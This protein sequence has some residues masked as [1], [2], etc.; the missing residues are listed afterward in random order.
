MIEKQ[1]REQI[2]KETD[3]LLQGGQHTFSFDSRDRLKN[4]CEL[5][6]SNRSR[7]YIQLSSDDDPDLEEDDEEE[8]DNDTFNQ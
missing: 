1:V 4:K 3:S 2:L 6:L 8:D 7:I 5:Q